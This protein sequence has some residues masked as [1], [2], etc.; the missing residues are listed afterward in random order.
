MGTLYIAPDNWLFSVSACM[1]TRELRVP[2]IVQVA[3][4]VSF[5]FI[6][7]LHCIIKPIFSDYKTM[8]I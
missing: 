7:V 4:S 8:L 1:L 2:W 5:L 3:F 6:Y